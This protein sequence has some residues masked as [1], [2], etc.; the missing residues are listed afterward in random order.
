MPLPPL[1]VAVLH[2]QPTGEPT[3]EVVE[4]I[5]AALR[6]LGHE[7]LTVAVHD[8]VTDILENIEKSHCAL[9]FNVCETFA[10]DYRMEVNIAA[11][12]ELAR[13][14]HTGSGTAGL[15]LAQD[16][17]VTKQLLE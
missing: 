10:D 13:V 15:L 16:K 2:Y 1:R 17:I 11:L 12:M 5:A 3:D 7:P 4:N 14:P 6:E 8:R 9:V